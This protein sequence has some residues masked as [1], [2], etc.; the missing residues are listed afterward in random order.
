MAS[1]NHMYTQP[2]D[3]RGHASAGASSSYHIE[4]A[5][6]REKQRRVA[7]DIQHRLH[8]RGLTEQ[9]QRQCGAPQNAAAKVRHVKK[10]RVASTSRH[11]TET[12]NHLGVVD[13]DA[14]FLDGI[15][16]AVG[17]EAG[18]EENVPPPSRTVRIRKSAVKELP[19]DVMEKIFQGAC[20]EAASVPSAPDLRV[21]RRK[22]FQ[23]VRRSADEGILHDLSLPPRTRHS[24]EALL[25]GIETEAEAEP[26]AGAEQQQDP[27]DDNDESKSPAV[28]DSHLS[29]VKHAREGTHEREQDDQ[30]DLGSPMPLQ[31]TT[32]ISLEHAGS[33]ATEACNPDSEE[34]EVKDDATAAMKRTQLIRRK[35]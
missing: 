10:Q 8:A 25:E 32:T 35:L 23:E 6:T 21:S 1:L 28:H 22:L 33:A 13:V 14:L 20:G 16:A 2:R 12:H 24:I 4:T 9:Q 11:A 29:F 3:A 30:S 17:G 7:R 5:E 19:L 18:D 15:A 26:K 34:D 31:K 27:N